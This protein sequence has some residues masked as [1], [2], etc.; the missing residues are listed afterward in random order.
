MAADSSKSDFNFLGPS[1][2]I[3]ASS[4]VIDV[5]IRRPNVDQH[6]SSTFYA[7][8]NPFIG[9]P[10]QMNSYDFP[11]PPST[12]Q[13][14]IQPGIEPGT[15][16]ARPSLSNR[17][18]SS[19]LYARRRGNASV[20]TTAQRI[21]SGIF[22]SFNARNAPPEHQWSVFGQLMENEVQFRTP[23]T[24]NLVNAD[25]NITPRANIADPFGASEIQ[26]PTAEEYTDHLQADTPS[27]GF[28]TDDDYDYDSDSDTIST[29][30]SS[31]EQ[32]QSKDTWFS[33]LSP[34]N[35]P[36]LYRNIFKCALAYFIG[37][38]FT[39]SPYLSGFISDITSYGPGERKPAPSGHMV[40]TM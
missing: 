23:R 29:S 19:P 20:P 37:S 18:I 38:L 12:S 7:G 22:G 39:F 8:D 14:T 33:S 25:E 3:R 11:E 30:P 36:L 27:R 5:P 26:S 24:S 31:E 34:N 6:D 9:S 2:T 15:R 40:A 35:I 10:D 13:S 1:D 17:S 21:T 16:R 32:P 4:S 28:S